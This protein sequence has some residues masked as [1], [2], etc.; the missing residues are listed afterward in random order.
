MNQVE[1]LQVAL[2][3]LRNPQCGLLTMLVT[4][5]CKLQVGF[6]MHDPIL[7]FEIRIESNSDYRRVESLHK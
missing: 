5:M 6:D 1:L 3:I 7:E 4:L 2:E